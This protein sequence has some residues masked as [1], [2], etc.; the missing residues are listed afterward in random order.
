[1]WREGE[2]SADTLADQLT[3]LLA[4]LPPQDDG[5]SDVDYSAAKYSSQ[6]A[7]PRYTIIMGGGGAT[8]TLGVAED[9]TVSM[10]RHADGGASRGSETPT[11]VTGELVTEWSGNF[12]VGQ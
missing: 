7:P 8:D 4:R 10:A 2:R 12:G 1:M 6:P 3:E 9:A 5:E 11:V